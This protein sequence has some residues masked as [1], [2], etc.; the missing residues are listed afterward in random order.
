MKILSPLPVVFALALMSAGAAHAQLK[1]P[2]SP[3]GDA[4]GPG[5]T[6]PAGKAAPAQPQQNVVQPNMPSPFSK[7]FQA[8]ITKAQEAMQAKK[9]EDP[10]AAKACIAPEVQRQ[11]AKLNAST[12]ALLKMVNPTEKKQL[13]EITAV[14]RRLRNAECAFFADPAGTPVES[15]DNAACMMNRT[16]GRALEMEG[17]KAGY[18]EHDAQR[19]AQAAKQPA[20]APAPAAPAAPAK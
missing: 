14:W 13:E 9:A 16:A 12:Q 1:V 3:G 11:E 20:P 15:A 2:A 17:L 18:L 10:V 6:P 7:E 5:L 19:K 4:S 8:C